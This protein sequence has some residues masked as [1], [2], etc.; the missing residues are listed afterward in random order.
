VKLAFYAVHA[1]M[2]LGANLALAQFS[3]PA[4]GEYVISDGA[5]GTLQVQPR[6]KFRIETIGANGHICELDGV[7][8]NG[9]SKL[10]KS[11]CQVSFKADG[12]N[13]NVATN[14]SDACR[15]FCGMR[16]WFEGLYRK[17]PP[18]CVSK[19]IRASRKKFKEEYVAK[20]YS[21]ALATIE[22]VATQCKQFLFW[23]ESGWILNDLALTQFKLGDRA[24]CIRTLQGLAPD[25]ALSDEEIKG[26]YPPTDAD[27]Y[28]PVVRA[29][30]TNLKLCT[31]R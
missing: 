13:V 19:S 15:D 6:G 7:I 24:G 25:A 3:T 31:K 14:E 11:A 30:R 12:Q 16:A 10:E 5:W 8:T 9:K 2:L 18:L 27:M 22:P 17:P 26:N 21:A 23:T 20:N 1:F 4:E 28:L 29:T